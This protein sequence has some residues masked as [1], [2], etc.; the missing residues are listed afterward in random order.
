MN[1]FASVFD[2]DPSLRLR[3]SLIQLLHWKPTLSYEQFRS[4]EL[5]PTNRQHPKES[6]L[7]TIDDFVMLALGRV[8]YLDQDIDSN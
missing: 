5:T 3:I 6:N 2:T 1:Q 4:L 8:L 7:Q